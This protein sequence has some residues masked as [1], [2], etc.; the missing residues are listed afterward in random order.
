GV[1]NDGGHSFSRVM[2]LCDVTIPSCGATSS[3][4]MQCAE[5][6]GSPRGLRETYLNGELCKPADSSSPAPDAGGPANQAA[7]RAHG[8]QQGGCACEVGRSGSGVRSFV[9]LIIALALRARR[10]RA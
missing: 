7:P 6:W 5:A 4:S 1:S 9:A 10:R 8:V 2:S 3:A